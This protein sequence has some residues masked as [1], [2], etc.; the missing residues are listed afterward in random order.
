MYVFR[1]TPTCLAELAS[2]S[3]LALTEEAVW[4]QRVGHTSTPVV[5]GLRGGAGVSVG[6]LTPSTRPTGLTA[7]L[8]L[9][10]IRLLAV[11]SVSAG[12]PAT[13]LLR[14]SCP[15]NTTKKTSKYLAFE[16]ST[17][18]DQHPISVANAAWCTINPNFIGLIDLPDPISTEDSW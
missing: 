1:E 6:Q 14:C 18:A 13:L 7:A 17:T 11:A 15:M 5:A 3:Q 4:T 9:P 8:E 16:A 10:H 12:L 2:P